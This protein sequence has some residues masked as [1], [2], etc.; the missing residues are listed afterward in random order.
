MASS[1]PIQIS[2]LA[3]NGHT[4]MSVTGFPRPGTVGKVLRELNNMVVEN[5]QWN[6]RERLLEILK[7]GKLGEW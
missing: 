4:V 7:S 6:R 1:P 3:I 2:D 5:P